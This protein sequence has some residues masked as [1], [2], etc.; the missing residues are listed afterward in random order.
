MFIVLESGKANKR[1]NMSRHKSDLLMK[2]P[3]FTRVYEVYQNHEAKGK[4]TS[5]T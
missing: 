1:K 2:T 4:T 3:H 5:K